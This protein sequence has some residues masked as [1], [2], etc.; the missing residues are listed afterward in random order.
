M[1]FFIVESFFSSLLTVIGL[2]VFC[3]VWTAFLIG[4]FVVL[5]IILHRHLSYSTCN[6]FAFAFSSSCLFKLLRMYREQRA[7]QK[8]MIVSGPPVGCVGLSW[9]T[10]VISSYSCAKYYESV[11][12]EVLWQLD[13]F[14]VT[15]QLFSDLI[16]LFATTFGRAFGN[17]VNSSLNEMQWLY[18]APAFILA[19]VCLIAAVLASFGCHL[20]IGYGLI[21]IDFYN[22]KF[23]T[24]N[25]EEKESEGKVCRNFV[26]CKRVEGNPVQLVREL[27]LKA[28]SNRS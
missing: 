22:R 6:L 15:A 10:D 19:S 4:V 1:L 25:P 21:K 11:D 24:A 16:I 7:I 17:L 13:I 12:S 9:L 27:Y 28:A 20:T 5:R 3:T 18:R 8:M 2:V 26:Q 14:H 23:R